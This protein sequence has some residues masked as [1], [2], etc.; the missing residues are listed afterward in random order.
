MTHSTLP[1]LARTLALVALGGIFAMG[2]A[3]EADAQRPSERKGE[4]V[5]QSL[6]LAQRGAVQN[7]ARRVLDRAVPQDYRRAGR[8]ETRTERVWV[9]GRTER[10]WVPA[11]FD[12]RYD[13][14]GIRVRYQT[15][16]GY[17]RAV[18]HAGRYERRSV[19]TW[20]PNRRISEPVGR[21]GRVGRR[22]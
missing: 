14:C 4:A 16:A 20:V 11:H 19:R 10:I 5:S 2:T 3:V 1:R 6:D 18:R 12:W 17:Y 22:R 13:R 9:P 21:R 15:R 7:R 8:Y